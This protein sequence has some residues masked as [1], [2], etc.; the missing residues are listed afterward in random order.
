MYKIFQW[1]SKRIWTICTSNVHNF[2]LNFHD[3]AHSTNSNFSTNLD[4]LY[5][6]CTQFFFEFLRF[7]TFNDFKFFIKFGLIV[8]K[9]TIFHWILMILYIQRIWS[10]KQIRTICASNVHNFPLNFHDFVFLTKS[11]FST[12]LDCLYFWCTQ[13]SIKFSWFGTFIDFPSN[14]SN[15]YILWIRIILQIRMICMS[16]VQN[17]PLNFHDFVHSRNLNF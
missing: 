10:F 15:L 2:P 4:Y 3:F 11:I 17:F 16:N 13:F 7:R 6:Y 12:S 1:I 9:Q 14:F 5:I 8:H